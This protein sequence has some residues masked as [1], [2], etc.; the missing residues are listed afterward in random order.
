MIEASMRCFSDRGETHLPNFFPALKVRLLSSL[1]L[2]FSQEHQPSALGN[3]SCR[4][5]RV[6]LSRVSGTVLEVVYPQ[7]VFIDLG[8]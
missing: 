1:H 4:A 8:L 2:P 3:P 6:P 7:R 5:G